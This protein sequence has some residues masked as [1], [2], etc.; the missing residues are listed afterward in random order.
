VTTQKLWIVL[1]ATGAGT[2]AIRGGFLLLAHRFVALPESVG[3]VLRMIPP[4]VFAAL[5]V[6]AIL[7]TEGQLDLWGPRPLAGL[8][9]AAVAYVTRNV[10]ATIVVGM[11]AL[12][13][14]ERLPWLG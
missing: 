13:G 12:V 8:A 6:P 5:V 14:L 4:A 9:A 3:Q 7:R 2:F 10:L 1:L 11:V